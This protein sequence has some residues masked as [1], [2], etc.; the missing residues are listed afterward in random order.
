MRLPMNAPASFPNIIVSLLNRLNQ[1]KRQGPEL[2]PPTSRAGIGGFHQVLVG[3][4]DQVPVKNREL[5]KFLAV[6][7]DWHGT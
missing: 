1:M 7:R 5:F 3:E 2:V 4:T 6:F